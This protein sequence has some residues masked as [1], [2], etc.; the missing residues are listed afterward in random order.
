MSSLSKEVRIL[1]NKKLNLISLKKHIKN[2]D[3]GN[4]YQSK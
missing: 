2:E 3:R 4:N 1:K